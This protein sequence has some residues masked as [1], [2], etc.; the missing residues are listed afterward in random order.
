MDRDTAVSRVQRQLGFRT[1]LNE[2]IVDAMQ[3]AQVQLEAEETL[4]WFLQ[5]EISSISTVVGEERVKL[6]SDFIREWEDDPLW[7]FNSSAEE[8]ED[9]WN[10]LDKGTDLGVLRRTYSGEGPP[11]A[12]HLTADYF[13]VFPTPDEI[14]TLKM[15]Y[16][17]NALVLDTNIENVWLKYFP[18]L[19]IGKAGVSL[20]SSLRDK[21]A[22]TVFAALELT[23]HTAMVHDTEARR[24]ANK[25]YIMGGPD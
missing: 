2:Q 5:S 23:N 17:K 16:Y 13:R 19:L 8:D 6:P 3:D 24:H 4:P 7:Y 14:Y 11:Q 1:D 21:N 10:E 22:L 25:R 20:A 12:Y 15:T 18:W 9:V